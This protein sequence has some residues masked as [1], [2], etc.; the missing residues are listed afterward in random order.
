MGYTPEQKSIIEQFEALSDLVIDLKDESIEDVPFSEINSR[1]QLNCALIKKFL[2]TVLPDNDVIS[3]HNDVDVFGNVNHLSRAETFIQ[4]NETYFNTL[5]RNSDPRNTHINFKYH[6][7]N[8]IHY[9]QI[10]SPITYFKIIKRGKTGSYKRDIFPIFNTYLKI[11]QDLHQLKAIKNLNIDAS[12]YNIPE[13]DSNPLSSTEPMSSVSPIDGRPPFSSLGNLMLLS[14]LATFWK[15]KIDAPQDEV[16]QQEN[17]P[18]LQAIDMDID[19]ENDEG[20]YARSSKR[21]K[22]Q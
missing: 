19:E 6:L 17:V 2:M 14:E 18:P 11:S 15:E 12:P 5:F 10:Q 13:T 7:D 22:T 1:I 9:A 4:F 3:K 21:F 16:Q 8:M 20:L